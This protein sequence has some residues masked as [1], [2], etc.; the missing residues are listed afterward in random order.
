[1]GA[2]TAWGPGGQRGNHSQAIGGIGHIAGTIER[3]DYAICLRAAGL[4][5]DEILALLC[6]LKP[7]SDL[8]PELRSFLIGM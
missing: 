6:E 5:R 2:L 1:M 7:P 8:V 3:P 4:E